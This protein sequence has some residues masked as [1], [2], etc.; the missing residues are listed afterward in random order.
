M[1]IPVEILTNIFDYLPRAERLECACV[2][3]SWLRV[4]LPGLDNFII[5]SN[6]IELRGALG[7]QPPRIRRLRFTNVRRLLYIVPEPTRR[8]NELRQGVTGDIMDMNDPRNFLNTLAR[9]RN[10]EM[11]E[12]IGIEN[13]DYL[14]WRGWNPTNLPKLQ[15]LHARYSDHPTIVSN[16]NAFFVQLAYK[17]RQTLTTLNLI[18]YEGLY[19]IFTARDNA[20]ILTYLERFQ[21]LRHLTIELESVTAIRDLLNACPQLETLVLSRVIR[22]LRLPNT[23]RVLNLNIDPLF[24]HNLQSLTLSA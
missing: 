22:T 17:C 6:T 1:S 10:L 18:E 3:R 24:Q 13:F 23:T 2:S 11:L 20:T 16:N 12:V 9:F 7:R 5:V 19:P 15:V 14:T 8:F 21:G 4:A